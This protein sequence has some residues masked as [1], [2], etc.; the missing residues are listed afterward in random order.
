M[1]FNL[2]RNSRYEF[3]DPEEKFQRLQQIEGYYINRMHDGA[4][5]FLQLDLI[6][7]YPNRRRCF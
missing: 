4:C 7:K 5:G 2:A 1:Y 3:A 6:R